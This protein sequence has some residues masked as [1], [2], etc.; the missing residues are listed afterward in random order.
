MKL[1]I[2]A[3]S[4][5]GRAISCLTCA[6]HSRPQDVP[7]SQHAIGCAIRAAAAARRSYKVP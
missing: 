2:P 1:I 5:G 4:P 3:G 6:T 7:W